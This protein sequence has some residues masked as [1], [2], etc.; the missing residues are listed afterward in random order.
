MAKTKGLTLLQLVDVLHENGF[1]SLSDLEKIPPN[2]MKWT[3][4]EWQFAASVISKGYGIPKS[5]IGA[6]FPTA[7]KLLSAYHE[8]LSKTG[9][10]IELERLSKV[11]EKELMRRLEDT[12]TT[13]I[14]EDPDL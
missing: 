10:L 4:R 6:T 8:I 7:A 1:K 3:R 2:P 9:L 11:P 14:W 13:E 5:E 12:D